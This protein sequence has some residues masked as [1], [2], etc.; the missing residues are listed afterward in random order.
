MVLSVDQVIEIH[1]DIIRDFGGEPGLRDPAT[2]DYTI[3]QVNRSRTIYKKAAIALFGICTGH[4]F[5]DGN[6]RTALV[7][8]D[9]LVREHHYRI[10]STNEDVVVFM[11]EVASYIHNLDS[12][13]FWIKKNTVWED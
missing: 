5:V 8:A 7:T 13:E 12:V 4:P 2:L 9:N 10:S 3:Y 6:K 1:N 11:L